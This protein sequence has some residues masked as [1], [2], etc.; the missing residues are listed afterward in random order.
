MKYFWCPVAGLRRRS[1]DSIPAAEKVV[2]DDVQI[3]PV[4]TLEEALA[5]L[6]ALGGDPIPAGPAAPTGQA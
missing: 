2:G 1:P 3:I 6:E 5:A 4:A